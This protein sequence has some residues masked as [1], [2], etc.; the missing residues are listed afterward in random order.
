[1]DNKKICGDYKD[2]YIFHKSERKEICG[3]FDLD[4]N[5]LCQHDNHTVCLF[6]F[7]K[8]NINKG[9]K[10]KIKNK[11]IV[12]VYAP[13]TILTFGAYTSCTA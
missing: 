5:A 1:M 2:D 10:I 6:Y 7:K 11:I 13:F 3:Y 8:H 12:V 4:T 9:T